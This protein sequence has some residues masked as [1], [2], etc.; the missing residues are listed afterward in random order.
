MARAGMDLKGVVSFHGALQTQTP[1]K[2]GD[3]KAKILVLHGAADPMVTTEHVVN[4][5]KEMDD[6]GVNWQLNAY[7]DAVHAFTNP[8][9]DKHNIPGVAYNEQAD[10]RSWQAMQMFWDEVFGAVK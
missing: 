7:S 1:A 3:V 6:A 5:T 10:R 8:N 2:K 9:A 4:F